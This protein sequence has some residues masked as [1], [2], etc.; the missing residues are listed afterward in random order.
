MRSAWHA[1]CQNEP[2]R[3]GYADV[4]ADG[5]VLHC[6]KAFCY[7]CGV[8]GIGEHLQTPQRRKAERGIGN[9]VN[10][11]AV[12]FDIVWLQGNPET[13]VGVALAIVI[14]RELSPAISKHANGGY[15]GRQRLRASLLG[16]FDDDPFNGK[17]HRAQELADI[18]FAADNLADGLRTEIE[19]QFSWQA[20]F[21]K[22][23]DAD[24]SGGPLESNHAALTPCLL[25][26]R[27]G[28]FQSR[29][30]RTSNQCLIAQDL[31]RGKVP[32]GLEHR[33]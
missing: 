29:P 17:L 9:T 6:L 20:R 19:K 5:Q 31:S 11:G 26:E 23:T 21:R 24:P 25:E 22:G 7:Q 16:K 32:D 4:T 30:S 15:E 13:E 8:A 1:A 10:D 18:A 27:L 33:A 2:L 28:T 12:N 14:Q 3:A